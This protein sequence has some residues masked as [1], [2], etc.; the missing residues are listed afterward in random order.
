MG[1][2]CDAYGLADRGGLLEAILWWQDRCWRGI[3]ERAAAGHPAMIRLRDGGAAQFVRDA[4]DWV[5]AHRDGLA[6]HV[7]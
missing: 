3:E 6:A 2:V 7:S 5:S 4:F 1:L